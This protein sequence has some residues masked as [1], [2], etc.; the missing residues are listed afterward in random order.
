MWYEACFTIMLIEKPKESHVNRH[1]LNQTSKGWFFFLDWAFLF[2]LIKEKPTTFLCSLRPLLS[3]QTEWEYEMYCEKEGTLIQKWYQDNWSYD[4][5]IKLASHCQDLAWF[6]LWFCQ[7]WVECCSH[8]YC[9]L[10][11]LVCGL[12]SSPGTWAEIPENI[13]PQ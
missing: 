9:I 5:I 11:S 6:Y 2:T 1:V 13:F 10:S 7:F 8:Y 12:V 4:H 3:L